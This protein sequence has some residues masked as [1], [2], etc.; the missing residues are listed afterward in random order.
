MKPPGGLQIAVDGPNVKS[1]QQWRRC[2]IVKNKKKVETKEAK[3]KAKVEM[4]GR[5]HNDDVSIC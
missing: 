4:A 1:G 5:R 3:T 2:R